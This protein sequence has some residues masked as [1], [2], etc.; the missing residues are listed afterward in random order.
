MRRK[1]PH[2][3]LICLIRRMFRTR[4]YLKSKFEE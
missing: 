3:E 2:T 4:L 1:R